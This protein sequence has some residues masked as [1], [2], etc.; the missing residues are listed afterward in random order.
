MLIILRYPLAKKYLGTALSGKPGVPS[1]PI[2]L[3]TE[4]SRDLSGK[5]V[6][7]LSDINLKG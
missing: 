6:V 2:M 1:N 3:T 7:F 5:D 4:A